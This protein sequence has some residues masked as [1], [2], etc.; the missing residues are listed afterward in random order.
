[1]SSSLSGSGELV[2]Q[3]MRKHG[4]GKLEADIKTLTAPVRDRNDLKRKGFTISVEVSEGVDF[5][6][7]TFGSS[8][9]IRAMIQSYGL[10]LSSTFSGLTGPEV[11][12]LVL[13]LC[14]SDC[15]GKL[16]GAPHV[17]LCFWDALDTTIDFTRGCWSL[18]TP[19]GSGL[20]DRC[21]GSSL[22]T[23]F[24]I[25]VVVQSIPTC[26]LLLRPSFS[27]RPFLGSPLSQGRD[28]LCL[29]WLVE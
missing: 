9:C 27:V 6:Y 29:F 12:L 21:H 26:T 24:W 16:G 10:S 8:Q 7:I 20:K 13:L 25:P 11:F 22:K 17:E 23:G 18:L 19:D 1:M 14:P 2:E 4:Q 15:S 3:V 5:L 28:W